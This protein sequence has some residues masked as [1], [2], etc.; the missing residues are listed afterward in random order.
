[1][2]VDETDISRVQ[3]V[4]RAY[5]MADAFGQ[6][7]FYGRMIRVGTSAMVRDIFS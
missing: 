5:V 6:Q 2:E 4:Q 1:M 7:K 3:A